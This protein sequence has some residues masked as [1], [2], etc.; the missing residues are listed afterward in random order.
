MKTIRLIIVLFLAFT[1]TGHAQKD[2]ELS[3]DQALSILL[4][5]YAKISSVK[6][7]TLKDYKRYLAKKKLNVKGMK[8][9]KVAALT[10][11]TKK[12]QKRTVY[13]IQRA[14]GMSFSGTYSDFNNAIF[15]GNNEAQDGGGDD[16][17]EI[18]CEIV[19]NICKVGNCT[20]SCVV[21]DTC[22]GDGSSDPNCCDGVTCDEGGG[23]GGDLTTPL[24]TLMP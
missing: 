15:D 7:I 9:K 16:D 1:L 11:Y 5:D 17:D 6:A 3:V 8:I 10:Y 4:V 18:I 19:F 14:G 13:L 23:I 12:K 22:T 20:V 2:K 21:S 24:E